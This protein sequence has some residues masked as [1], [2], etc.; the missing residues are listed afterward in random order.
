M[1]PPIAC[2]VSLQPNLPVA[3]PSAAATGNRQ[4]SGLRESYRALRL[5]NDLLDQW[6]LAKGT[7]AVGVTGGDFQVGEGAVS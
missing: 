1:R 3:D 5:G 4:D 2:E 6:C 7:C